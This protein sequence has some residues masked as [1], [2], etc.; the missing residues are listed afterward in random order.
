MRHIS[1]HHQGAS[2]IFDD[3]SGQRQRPDDEVWLYQLYL[4]LSWKLHLNSSRQSWVHH[5]A[6]TISSWKSW[7]LF[8]MIFWVQRSASRATSRFG[9]DMWVITACFTPSLLTTRL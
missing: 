5:H 2:P 3:G 6:V 1:S 8:S 4:V 7:N 9:L